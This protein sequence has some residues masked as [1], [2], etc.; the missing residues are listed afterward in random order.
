M[1]DVESIFNDLLDATT[2]LGDVTE[3]TDKTIPGGS[4]RLDVVKKETGTAGDKSPWPGR[5]MVK[6]QADAMYKNGDGEFAR[7]G[8]LFFDLSPQKELDRRGKLDGPYRLW[9]N[10]VALVGRDAT[11]RE[12]LE[13]I[14]QFPL[15]ATVSRTFKTVEGK[16][17]NART[18]DEEKRL[19]EEGAE[20][21]NFVQ[22]LRAFN[23]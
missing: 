23:G 8:R 22:S 20:P 15:A 9:A 17:T 18:E 6:V 1:N 16:Y 12:V 4:Y 7:R 11:N 3:A 21:R 2:P 14:G 13:Y 10:L 19:L 5:F